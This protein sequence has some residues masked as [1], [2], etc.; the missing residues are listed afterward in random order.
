MSYN[1][2]EIRNVNQFLAPVRDVQTAAYRTWIGPMLL[3]DVATL[4]ELHL[5]PYE[6]KEK[7]EERQRFDVDL[8]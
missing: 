2:H 4:I 8:S 7:H 6:I 3:R 5:I 1:R